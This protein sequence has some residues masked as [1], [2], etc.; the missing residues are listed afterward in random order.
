MTGA[1]H[2]GEE[3][4][5]DS[6]SAEEQEPAADRRLPPPLKRFDLPRWVM[7]RSLVVPGWGQFHN[8]AWLK[9]A[10]VAALDGTL[11]VRAFL[12]ERRLADLNDDANAAGT[13]YDVYQAR[14]SSA[15][16]ALASAQSELDAAQASG[17]A[18][19]IRR[20]TV[21]VNWATQRLLKA[22]VALGA[23]NSKF[24]QVADEYNTLFDAAATRRWFLG[25][26]I[27]YSLLDAYVDAH[28]KNFGVDFES[29][30]ALPGG[31]PPGS[32]RLSLRWHF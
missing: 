29:D 20:A 12:D 25:A 7:L 2:G 28:F 22:G 18:L 24:S 3:A 30:P 19:A 21:R 5:A 15:T 27:A 9:A 10:M 8:R 1:R 16:A 6:A 11:R 32:V 13:A 14:Q 26:V 4:S 17:N 23:A 31:K